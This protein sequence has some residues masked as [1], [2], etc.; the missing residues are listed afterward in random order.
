MNVG[1]R[2]PSIGGWQHGW[3]L[4]M[5]LLFPTMAC[6]HYGRDT[7]LTIRPIYWLS[8]FNVTSALSTTLLHLGSGDA[9]AYSS[10]QFHHLYGGVWG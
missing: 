8:G 9:E 2:M 7:T 1:G 4:M 5:V 6:K 3:A 10:C